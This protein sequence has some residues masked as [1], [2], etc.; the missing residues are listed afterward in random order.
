[1]KILILSLFIIFFTNC[2][3]EKDIEKNQSKNLENTTSLSLISE[4]KKLNVELSKYEVKS[5]IFTVSAKK[6]NKVKS[7]LGTIIY[8]N[9]EELENIDG[10]KIEG[11][12]EIELK[13]LTNQ[14]E[15]LRSNAQTIS[16]GKLLVS[17]G[18]YFLNMKS[19]GKQLKIKNGKYLK[20]D[21]PKYSD[22]E[23]LLFY[24]KKDSLGIMNWEN[25]NTK[26]INSVSIKERKSE[27]TETYI[28]TLL[29]KNEDEIYDIIA[30]TDKPL[31]KKEKKINRE[32]TKNTKL[33]DKI[34][35]SM[36]LN[37]FGWINCD[38]FYEIENTT[39]IEYE[40]AEKE[41][42][43][44]SNIYLVFR[45]INSVMHKSF[46]IDDKNYKQE[47]D[48]VPIGENVELIAVSIKNEK[49]FVYKSKFKVEKNKKQ[50]IIL[51]EANEQEFAE[52]LK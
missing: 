50:T 45:D 8:V 52:L 19:N 1:M 51:K 24:G 34:Y 9:P 30:Y 21:F 46:F 27:V 41:N 25:A 49:K 2:K 37:N 38:R 11:N 7:R 16:N 12:I 5:Q 26:F 28:D 3:N 13:E 4:I 18:A 22:K 29:E 40:F 17:G 14:N 43:I 6:Q 31:T 44:Y 20:V 36:K 15:L 33:N 48:K 10:T 39:N 32:I 42:L 35:N 47:F 23:M